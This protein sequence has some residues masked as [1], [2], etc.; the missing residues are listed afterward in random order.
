[1]VILFI[2]AAFHVVL[3]VLP[4]V[5]PNNFR[6]AQGYPYYIFPVAGL[7]ILSLGV[8]YWVGWAK[9]FPLWGGYRIE[10]TRSVGED[11]GEVVKFRKVSSGGKTSEASS[12]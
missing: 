1:M 4:L 8:L 7:G 11:G 10:A 3:L 2:S 6:N 5:P 12:T 9:V